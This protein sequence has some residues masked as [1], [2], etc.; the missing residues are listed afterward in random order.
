M[1]PFINVFDAEMTN[2]NKG[3]FKHYIVAYLI[4][5]KTL[6]YF[7]QLEKSFT[8]KGNKRPHAH[9]LTH[10]RALLHKYSHTNTNISTDIHLKSHVE[11]R[12][13]CKKRDPSK[14]CILHG[15]C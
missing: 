13:V 8:V 3:L 7:A 6:Y 14:T 15:H 4:F 10:I 9:T 11:T 5:G 2:I 12:T 1:V